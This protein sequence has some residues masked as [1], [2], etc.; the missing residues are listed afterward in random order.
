MRLPGGAELRGPSIGQVSRAL[1][2]GRELAT[3][4]GGRPARGRRRSRGPRRRRLRRLRGP[5]HAGRRE[6]GTRRAGRVVAEDRE[7][8]RLPGGDH[9]QRAD[10]PRRHPGA[11]VRRAAGHALPRGRT[12]ARGRA[13]RRAAGGRSRDRRPRRADRD[14]RAIPAPARRRPRPVRG[15]QRLLRRG[16]AR[17]AALRRRS[18]WPWSAEGT[19]PDR[20]PSGSL[21]AARW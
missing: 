14:R 8:S 16:T 19:Q 6:H 5:G 12:R 7:L 10:Q 2:I 11:E 13:P 18:G 20:P 4:R 17:G 15:H 21:A 1:G 3:A 9:R